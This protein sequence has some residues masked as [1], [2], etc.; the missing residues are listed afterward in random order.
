M[1]NFSHSTGT[2]FYGGMASY[3]QSDGT[4]KNATNNFKCRDVGHTRDYMFDC[5]YNGNNADWNNQNWPSPTVSTFTKCQDCHVGA[6]NDGMKNRMAKFGHSAPQLP[7]TFNH[8]N[9][10]SGGITYW[11]GTYS[12]CKYCHSR[13]HDEGDPIGITTRAAGLVSGD[14]PNEINATINSKTTSWCGSCHI[15]GDSDYYWAVNVAI[16]QQRGLPKPPLIP[17]DSNHSGLSGSADNNCAGPSC[18]YSGD[19]TTDGMAQFMH[20]LG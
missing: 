17:G 9:G 2:K 13:K 18:H 3:L 19:P 15:S 1:G 16:R 12:A 10:A 4:L 8:G 14:F 6:P 7:A 11:S 5:T 20:N